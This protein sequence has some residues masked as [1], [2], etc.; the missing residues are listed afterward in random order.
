MPR[1][2]CLGLYRC[3]VFVNLLGIGVANISSNTL[4]DWYSAVLRSVQKV[5][6]AQVTSR[7]GHPSVVIA[8]R[9]FG[10]SPSLCGASLLVEFLNLIGY[11]SGYA[12]S[13]WV[14]TS[15]L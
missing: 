14:C 8:S 12:L 4:S 10:S 6:T 9:C 5:N 13:W 15:A 1:M 3:R 2:D 7:S 11:F